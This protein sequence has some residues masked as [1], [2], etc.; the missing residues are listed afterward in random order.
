[1]LGTLS[2]R[3]GPRVCWTCATRLLGSS[4]PSLSRRRLCRAAVRRANSLLSTLSL[5]QGPCVCWT[6][7]SLTTR[8]LSTP[9]VTEKTMPRCCSSQTCVLTVGGDKPSSSALNFILPGQVFYCRR[10]GR[11]HQL[12]CIDAA[13]LMCERQA[14]FSQVFATQQQI[15][16]LLSDE[17]SP[18]SS[19]LDFIL[20]EQVSYCRRLGRVH[21]LFA[22]LLQSSTPAY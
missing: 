20:P 4:A 22:S 7:A 3:Q 18:M 11:D 15:A 14:T 21:Q 8:Q 19:A 5:R 16:C 6:F 13:P 2:L 10:L 12:R 9:S 17:T 1:M